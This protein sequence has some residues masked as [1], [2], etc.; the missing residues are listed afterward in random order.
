MLVD[1]RNLTIIR[2][3]RAAM[4]A[5]FD[6]H[7]SFKELEESCIP[8]YC[9][10][11]VAAAA[12]SWWRLLSAC[13]LYRRYGSPGPILDFG[14]ASGELNHLLQPKD[15][16]HFVE[17]SEMLSGALK[18]QLPDARREYLESLPAATFEAIFALDSLEHND[19][20]E[21]ILE[22]LLPSLR[23][24]GR[25]FICGPT[26]SALYRLGRRI[27]GFEGSYHH[28]TIYEIERSFAQRVERVVLQR[29]PP[30]APLFRLSV[31]KRR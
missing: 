19:D 11:N 22:A 17:E 7:R 21:S 12:I 3:R 23:P 26:E 2:K 4:R 28:T 25:L 27:A 30:L 9:H 31:W 6:I 20:I 13:E 10:D 24:S 14:A 18:R 5:E 15:A 1:P 8:S 16:Y 29:V